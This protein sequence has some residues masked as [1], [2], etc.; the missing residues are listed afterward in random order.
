MVTNSKNWVVDSG[1]IRH[2]CGNRDV[3]TPYTSVGDAK[4]FEDGITC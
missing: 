2:I 1:A 3:F 4:G